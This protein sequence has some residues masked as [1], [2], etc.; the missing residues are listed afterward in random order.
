MTA[1]EALK[2]QYWQDKD[3]AIWEVQWV[4]TEPSVQLGR[5]TSPWKSK[6]QPAMN[7]L[8]EKLDHL[9]GGVSGLTFQGMRPIE[10]PYSNHKSG[11]KDE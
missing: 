7:S 2:Y 4:I 9:N 6:A 10:L 5:M 8:P 1:D 11:D 3:G